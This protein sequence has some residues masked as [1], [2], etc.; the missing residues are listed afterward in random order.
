MN[1]NVRSE[2]ENIKMIMSS[3]KNKLDDSDRSD[4]VIRTEIDKLK[5]EMSDTFASIVKKNV[6]VVNNEVKSVQK[7]LHENSDLKERESNL[8][9]FCLLENN[10]DRSN[11]LKVLKHLS[12]DVSDRDVIKVT[13]LGKKDENKTRPLLIKLVDVAIKDSIMRNVY[14]LKSITNEFAHIGLSVDLTKEQRQEYKIFVNDA[15]IKES[16]DKEGFLYRVRGTVGKWRIIKFPK[17]LVQ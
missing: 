3:N 8:I 12:D 7:T 9:V 11:V 2:I 14:K 16:A 13:R 10:N 4:A 6:D 15:K 1:L 5:S 17:R